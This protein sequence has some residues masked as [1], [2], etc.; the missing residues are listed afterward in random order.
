MQR[1]TRKDVELLCE[2]IIVQAVDD[3]KD[4]RM[5]EKKSGTA[6]DEVKDKNSGTYGKQEIT[7]FFLSKWGESIIQDGLH[8]EKSG[9][10]FLRAAE[11]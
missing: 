3:Y 9:S 5:R 2:A 8:M 7:D 10:D 6:V 1:L 11:A 4:I